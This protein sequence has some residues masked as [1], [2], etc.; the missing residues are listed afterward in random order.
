MHRRDPN[1]PVEESVGAMAELV[2]EG[3][4]RHLGLSEVSA[5]TLRAAHAVHP[6]TALQSEWSL[7]TRGSLAWASCPTARR[8]LP[9]ENREHNPH[10]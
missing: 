4:V 9:G 1:V 10:S 3:K 5:E 2:K 7:F 8:P 6:I